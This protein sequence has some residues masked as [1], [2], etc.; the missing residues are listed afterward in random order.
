MRET[1]HPSGNQVKHRAMSL[2]RLS[3][4]KAAGGRCTV[5]TFVPGI[6]PFN[7]PPGTPALDPPPPPAPATT[8]GSVRPPPYELIWDGLGA[9]R[10]GKV[11]SLFVGAMGLLSGKRVAEGFVYSRGM[12][13]AMPIRGH[14]CVAFS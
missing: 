14:I 8:K 9:A 5:G 11:A 1:W 13:P 6:S 12:R 10:G 4:H 2:S 3:T 7:P